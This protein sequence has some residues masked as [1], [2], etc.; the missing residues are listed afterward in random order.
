ML[1]AQQERGVLPVKGEQ[2]DGGMC[3]DIREPDRIVELC[4]RAR[5][6]RVLP[7]LQ[8]IVQFLRRHRPAVVVA[9]DALT[10]DGAQEAHLFLRLD[11]LSQSMDAN[12]LGHADD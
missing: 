2:R 6:A 9:L 1:V 12:L 3:G 11:A 5:L 7:P 8:G 4:L 10:A